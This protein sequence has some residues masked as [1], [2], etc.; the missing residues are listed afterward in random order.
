MFC[1]Q[2]SLSFLSEWQKTSCI[3]REIK[4]PNYLLF[5]SQNSFHIILKIYLL[6]SPAL[7]AM[8]YV[9]PMEKLLRFILSLMLTWI[10]LGTHYIVFFIAIVKNSKWTHNPLVFLII[11][12]AIKLQYIT[13]TIWQYS[14]NLKFFLKKLCSDIGL[15]GSVSFASKRDLTW[16]FI[17]G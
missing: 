8:E 16:F 17:I 4:I 13:G 12:T 6:V 10:H 7:W 15:Y 14:G 9:L 3:L 5:G 2:W 11:N 1:I